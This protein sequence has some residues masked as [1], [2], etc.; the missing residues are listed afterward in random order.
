MLTIN[1]T[2]YPQ[3]YAQ[4]LGVTVRSAELNLSL[5]GCLNW[6]KTLQRY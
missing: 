1:L 4:N 2:V 5:R 6:D 3:A